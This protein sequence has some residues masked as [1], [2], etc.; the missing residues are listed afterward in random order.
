MD[1]PTCRPNLTK[2]RHWRC[3]AEES[4]R[5]QGVGLGV[6]YIRCVCRSAF[7]ILM[8]C[9]STCVPGP[10]EFS[11]CRQAFA[12]LGPN[13]FDSAVFR[14]TRGRFRPKLGR[15]RESGPISPRCWPKSANIGQCGPASA[16]FDRFWAVSPDLFGSRTL[17]PTNSGPELG[18]SRPTSATFWGSTNVGPNS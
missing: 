2:E 11:E 4:G 6:L 15:H 16:N 18:R 5:V 3:E 8:L 14:L 10:C 17:F 12:P 1:S 13:P 7:G 9:C